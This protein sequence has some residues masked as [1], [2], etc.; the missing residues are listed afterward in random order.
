MIKGIW[1]REG[2]SQRRAWDWVNMD[3]VPLF[4]VMSIQRLETSL[5]HV[6]RRFSTLQMGILRSKRTELIRYP[7]PGLPECF[8]EPVGCVSQRRLVWNIVKGVW[9]GSVQ[10]RDFL[11]AP[12]EW[13]G[14]L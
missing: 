4:P 8:G 12:K 5:H 14:R 6:S 9:T 10:G 2:K 1:Q 13:M 11:V 7:H 3:E